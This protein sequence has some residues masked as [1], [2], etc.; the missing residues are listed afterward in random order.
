MPVG[1]AQDL[2]HTDSLLV[3]RVRAEVA[4]LAPIEGVFL[5][6]AD[7]LVE[8]E[9]VGGRLVPSPALV[10]D[11]AHEALADDRQHRG[12]DEEGLDPHVE[13]SVQRGRGVGR[14]QRRQHEVTGERGLHGD[15]RGLDVADLADEDHVGVL[16][17]DRL[18]PAG[19]GDVGG[20]VDLDLVDGGQDV[21]DRILDRHHVALR[22][23]E[24]RRAWRRAWW[25]C[26]SPSARRRSPCRTEIAP[27]PRTRLRSP[28]AFRARR[29]CTASASCRGG[30]ARP[31]RRRSPASMRHGCRASVHPRSS[32]SDRPA[33]ADARRCSSPP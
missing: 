17:E 14:V 10:A 26:R 20:L 23:V 31:S 9:L 11:P 13:E 1:H 19:E 2:V 16:T 21:L 5:G 28:P 6:A 29:A 8:G 24:R 25:S 33:R 15:A 32:R 27:T 18:E 30:G 22:R 12:R 7:L 4:A 3:A